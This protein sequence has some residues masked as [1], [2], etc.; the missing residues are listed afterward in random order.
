MHSSQTRN[1]RPAQKARRRPSRKKHALPWLIV[2]SIITIVVLVLT[3]GNGTVGAWSAD[4][5]REIAGPVAAA[6]VEAW[7]LDLQNKFNQL[8][9]QLGLQHI[10]APSQLPLTMA[11]SAPPPA[12]VAWKAMPLPSMQPLISPVLKGEGSW[13]M[14]EQ[15]PGPYAYLPIDAS[16]FIRPDP[17]YP[18]AIVTLLQFDM[19]FSRLHIVAG[20]QEPGGPL[21]AYGT[22]SIAQADQAGNTLLA[23]LNGGFKY[24]DGAYG[25]MTD[26]R[27]YVPPQPNVATIAITRNGKLIIGSWGVDPELNSQNK[28]LLAW[29]QNASLLI[30]HG[31]I[32]PL[33]R[34]GAAWGGTILNKEYTWRSGLGI[35]AQGN[36]IYA[37]GNAL[38]PETLGKALSAA[39]AVMAMETDINPFWTRAFLYQRNNNGTLTINKLNTQMQGTGNEYLQADQRDF[40][41]LTRYTPAT[42]TAT[43]R[44]PSR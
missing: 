38:L 20:T 5:F 8:Q 39:G 19:R 3:Q 13:N 7:Y 10:T 31:A 15:A 32:N 9:Y 17:H 30:D 1:R 16:A 42:I 40:F 14:L 37:A 21:H 28:N 41:Y 25:L 23:V 43:N 22:G 18:Y 11:K 29:R 26:G 35:T 44:Y 34:D 4:E 6:Q 27:V 2:C 24:A 33:T 12:R 36:L